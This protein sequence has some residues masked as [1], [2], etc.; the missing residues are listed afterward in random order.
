MTADSDDFSVAVCRSKR[1]AGG[2]CKPNDR[3]RVD[4]QRGFKIH[5][6]QFGQVAKTTRRCV[7]DD[8]I[9][10]AELP[11]HLLNH[12]RDVVPRRD[13]GANEQNVQAK[14]I[15]LFGR[16]D[17]GWLRVKEIDRDRGTAPCLF[18]GD[19]ASDAPAGTCDQR[20]SSK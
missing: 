11:G 20:V 15:D 16:L 10:S 4:S 18:D 19:R 6:A 14:L 17:G 2:L 7:A 5:G 9:Q 3:R 13:I 1:L 8:D 12:R